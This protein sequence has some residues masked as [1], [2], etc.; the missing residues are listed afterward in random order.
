MVKSRDATYHDI[1]AEDKPKRIFSIKQGE[2]EQEEGKCILIRDPEMPKTERKLRSTRIPSVLNIT[3]LTTTRQNEDDGL[4]E[5]IPNTLYEVEFPAEIGCP[6][7]VGSVIKL[8]TEKLQ[9]LGLLEEFLEVRRELLHKDKLPILAK[10]AQEEDPGY[11][12]KKG[13]VYQTGLTRNPKSDPGSLHLSS[14]QRRQDE[15]NGKSINER[16]MKIVATAI[17]LCIP[18]VRGGGRE[19]RWYSTGSITPYADEN[20]E[21]TSIQMN[22]T[23]QKTSVSSSLKKFATGHTDTGDDR[24]GYSGVCVMG[25]LDDNHF[26]GRFNLTPLGMTTTLGKCEMLLF[27]AKLWLHC[28]SGSGTYDVPP[29]DARRIPLSPLDNLTRLPED[30]PLMRLN[31]VVYPNARCLNPAFRQIHK[32]FWGEKGLSI[33]P[34]IAAHQEW[35]MRIWIANE[36]EIMQW[37]GDIGIGETVG[38]DRDGKKS[39][40]SKSFRFRDHQGEGP[41]LLTKATEIMTKAFRDQINSWKASNRLQATVSSMKAEQAA[42]ASG[43][44]H[45]DPKAKAQRFKNE[46][47]TNQK[48][49]KEYIAKSKVFAPVEKVSVEDYC[50]LFAWTDE[51]TGELLY[52]SEECAKKTLEWSGKTNVEFEKLWKKAAYLDCGTRVSNSKNAGEEGASLKIPKV[53]W[54][55]PDFHDGFDPETDTIPGNPRWKREVA[56]LGGEEG[57]DERQVKKRSHAMAFQQAL[58]ISRLADS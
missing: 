54:F 6:G 9:E 46:K 25:H 38:K 15:W 33:Y 22:Y 1:E 29:G 39:N 27:P 52:P 56:V 19:E 40:T 58:A 14:L 2:G 30:T 51:D 45:E 4:I 26:P 10:I 43:S 36:S 24:T 37:L 17:Q 57:K 13:T 12:K 20:H 21:V 18:N 44:E 11:E 31:V 7:E 42:R 16:L 34:S 48:A 50:R 28:S 8:D 32:E 41:S 55:N 35:M 53:T 47:K 3:H 49:R 5:L 23:P